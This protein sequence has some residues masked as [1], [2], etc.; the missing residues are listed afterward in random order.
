MKIFD[1]I[2]SLFQKESLREESHPQLIRIVMLL[3]AAYQDGVLADSEQEVIKNLLHRKYNLTFEEIDSLQDLASQKRL[4]RPDFFGVTR[5]INAL[6]SKEEKVGLL[7]EIWQVILADGVIE[8][9]ESH[10]ASRL[11][12]LLRLDHEDWARA[13]QDAIAIQNTASREEGPPSK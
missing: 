4:E 1:R 11:K 2:L 10:L 8:K 7:T 6:M 13:R 5:E 9:H 12:T 3:E